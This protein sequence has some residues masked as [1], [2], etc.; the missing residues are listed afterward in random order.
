MTSKEEMRDA[1]LDSYRFRPCETTECAVCSNIVTRAAFG[2]LWY[3]ADPSDIL[4]PR[5]LTEHL[6]GRDT[7]LVQFPICDAC[8]PECKKC[9]LPRRNK[10]VQDLITE[11]SE[12]IGRPVSGQGYCDHTHILGFVF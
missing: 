4:P 9:H 3:Y 10:A 1:L 6:R 8:A 12:H 11:V 7:L 5:A 2:L